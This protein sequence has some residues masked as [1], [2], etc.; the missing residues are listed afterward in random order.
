MVLDDELESLNVRIRQL[1]SQFDLFFAGAIPKPPLEARDLLEKEV[2]RLGTTREMKLAQRFLYNTLLNRWN[3]FAELWNKKLQEKEEG[4][5]TPVIARRRAA[6]RRAGQ[7]AGTK[8]SSEAPASPSQAQNSRPTDDPS[9]PKRAA[10]EKKLVARAAIRDVV[11][12]SGEDMKTFYKSFLEAR[13]ETGSGKAP[14]YEKFCQEIQ[15]QAKTIRE[16][17]DC[18]R[19]DFRLYLED[20]RLSL[21]ANP[22]KGRQTREVEEDRT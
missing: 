3:I 8:P 10:S 19:V 1:R 14:S 18:E 6:G 2:K 9:A 16:K 7:T 4:A 20:N 12:A 22:V 17:T 15:R 5:R 21:K 11:D 13:Q